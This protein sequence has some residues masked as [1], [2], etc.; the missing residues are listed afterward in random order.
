MVPQKQGRRYGN[1]F[2]TKGVSNVFNLF[3]RK[4]LYLLKGSMCM[5]EVGR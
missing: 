2:K 3:E 5:A 1:A 4:N